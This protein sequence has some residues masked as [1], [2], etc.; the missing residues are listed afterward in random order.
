[1]IDDLPVRCR[2]CAP[3]R[4]THTDSWTLAAMAEHE[5]SLESWTLT[6]T[7][8][9][10]EVG[11]NFLKYSDIQNL[12]KRLRKAGHEF[13]YV[14][15]GELGGKKGRPHWHLIIFWQTPPPDRGKI[16]GY[17]DCGT[18]ERRDWPSWPHGHTVIDP[19][20]GARSVR[21]ICKYI[22]KADEGA[23]KFTSSKRPGIGQDYF[24][25]HARAQALNNAPIGRNE[26][27]VGGWRAS[28]SPN[29]WKRYRVQTVV[30]LEEIGADGSQLV[31]DTYENILTPNQQSAFNAWRD[32]RD[33]DQALL[34]TVTEVTVHY[35]KG[36]QHLTTYRKGNIRFLRLD[37]QKTKDTPAWLSGIFHSSAGYLSP[38][39]ASHARPLGSRLLFDVAISTRQFNAISK[40]QKPL[41]SNV[42]TERTDWLT[43]SA[44]HQRRRLLMSSLASEAPAL[45]NVP[46]LSTLQ[47]A[48][49]SSSDARAQWL[50]KMH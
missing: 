46:R 39:A 27:I 8:K 34:Q 32:Q 3:C 26:F 23:G 33:L 37:L 25:A 5:T 36:N 31:W 22:Q 47:L 16:I 43:R 28:L 2:K 20:F 14:C 10:G 30:T 18:Y 6:L 1:M 42:P 49:W 9:P 41:P 17:S 13:R 15:A 48:N 44:A 11:E 45:S 21:Y 38:G 4:Q 24:D 7:Y 35:A 19:I 29:R 40:R 50:S 12:M